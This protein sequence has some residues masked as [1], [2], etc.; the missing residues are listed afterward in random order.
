MRVSVVNFC[1]TRTDMLDFSSEMLFEQAGT[2]D[3]DYIVVT[4]LATKEVAEWCARTRLP[5]R[6]VIHHSVEGLPYVPQLRA[7]MN[8]GFGVGFE[9][10]PWVAIVNTDMAFGRDWLRNLVRRATDEDLIPN[11][12]HLTPPDA[13]YRGA[14]DV[15]IF[16]AN[17][18]IPTAETFDLAGFWR[19][20]DLLFEDRAISEVEA[21][22]GWE[23]CATFPYLLHRKWWERCGAWGLHFDGTEAP[24]RQFFRRC[25]DQGAQYL[26]CRDSIV[27]HHEAVERR[28]SR[29][30][31]AEHLEEGA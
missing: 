27:Y 24:D 10:N 20:H 14:Q 5:V 19:R 25:H 6:R 16:K 15:G 12:T 7:M 17:F 26:L 1:S 8:F 28:G 31:G 18:G 11:S 22:G 29:P 9:S 3:F 30:P 21:P 13:G 2:D 4:W 23:S